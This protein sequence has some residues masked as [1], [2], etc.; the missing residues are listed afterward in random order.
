ME[1]EMKIL[2]ECESGFEDACEKSKEKYK[3]WKMRSLQ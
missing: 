3:E 1:G 2:G